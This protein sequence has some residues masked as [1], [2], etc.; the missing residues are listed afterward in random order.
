MKPAG[1]KSKS[2]L[3]DDE[4][5]FLSTATPVMSNISQL[6]TKAKK[7]KEVDY[8][9][10][11]IDARTGKLPPT[12]EI[13]QE[14]AKPKKKKNP[15]GRKLSIRSA[16]KMDRRKSSK[17][18]SSFHNRP[19]VR[20]ASMS[21]VYNSYKDKKIQ[22]DEEDNSFAVIEPNIPEQEENENEEEKVNLCTPA[23]LLPYT[24]TLLAT[25]RFLLSTTSSLGCNFVLINIGFEPRNIKFASKSVKIGPWAYMKGKCLSYPKN[26]TKEFIHTSNWWR[27]S[28][29][30]AVANIGLGFAVFL[31]AAFVIIYKVLRLWPTSARATTCIK[32]FD[33]LWETILF[34]LVIFM[35]VFEVVKFSLWNVELCIDKVFMTDQY[36]RLPARECV[37][38]DGARASLA[39][40]VCDMMML[41][42][43]SVWSKN[44]RWMLWRMCKSMKVDKKEKRQ[45]S[46]SNPDD[47]IATQPRYFFEGEDEKKKKVAAAERQKLLSDDDQK[48]KEDLE[49][50]KPQSGDGDIGKH[51][52]E[53]LKMEKQKQKQ[54]ENELD[55]VDEDDDDDDDDDENEE[56]EDSNDD[57]DEDESS[58]DLENSRKSSKASKSGSVG[59]KDEDLL[60][61]EDI[62]LSSSEKDRKSNDL[63]STENKEIEFV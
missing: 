56:D 31:L 52:E 7:K 28:R 29:V 41:I 21:N 62:D 50:L 36:L 57:D 14:D 16:G 54:Y 35:F 26:F 33:K 37:L 6:P 10:M 3:E 44:L 30:S 51:E 39:A 25:L 60:G 22:H 23:L 20:E 11:V 2:Q 12:E 43:L 47:D 18:R 1:T 4:H 49:S 45:R 17:T 58:E 38:S 59:T 32:S 27:A 19:N 24:I 9:Q 13:S 15:I 55:D 40:I 48:S 63:K 46:E 53:W 8:G 61:F 34:V 42:I 5:S